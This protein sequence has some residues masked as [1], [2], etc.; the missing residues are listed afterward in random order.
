[1]SVKVE[2]GAGGRWM[3]LLLGLAFVGAVGGPTQ[4]G[5]IRPARATAAKASSGDYW[6]NYFRRALAKQS[7]D[8][9]FPARMQPLRLQANRV[10]PQSA[11]VRYL[12][13]RRGLNTR[14]FDAN[15]P[16][17]GRVLAGQVFPPRVITPAVI[18]PTPVVPSTPVVP[19]TP[20]RPSINPR[21]QPLIPPVVPE[22]SGFVIAACLFGAGLWARSR[23]GRVRG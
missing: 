15:H 7:K 14:R 16:R 5:P 3:G 2:G 18:T 17:I 13:W 1:M 21:A 8:V 10:L 9:R 11:M 23:R 6:E 12:E 19:A 22:P 4:A 20:V